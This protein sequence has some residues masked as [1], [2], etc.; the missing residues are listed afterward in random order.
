[1]SQIA[2]GGGTVVF[3]KDK[4]YIES[5]DGK[6]ESLI[7]RTGNLVA[8]KMWIPREQRASSSKLRAQA[9]FPGRT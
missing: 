6:E 8:L 9:G 1:M 5:P 3:G 2:R 7:E 4:S